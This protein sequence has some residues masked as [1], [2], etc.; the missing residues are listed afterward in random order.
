M[1]AATTRAVAAQLADARSCH[2]SAASSLASHSPVP[3]KRR[4]AGAERVC[5]RRRASRT[6]P[7]RRLCERDR[8][9]RRSSSPRG[10]PGAGPRHRLAIGQPAC[11]RIVEH[12]VEQVQALPQ[13]AGPLRDGLQPAVV[14][15]G[16][17]DVRAADVPADDVVLAVLM[18]ARS[19]PAL[20][21]R[22]AGA[23]LC[24]ASRA[25]AASA[26]SAAMLRSEHGGQ[27][28]VGAGHARVD[29]DDDRPRARMPDQVDADDAGEAGQGACASGLRARRAASRR[30]SRTG[31]MHTPSNRSH[32]CSSK[33]MHC[34][35]TAEHFGLI[36][37][38][39]SSAM[40]SGSPSTQGSSTIVAHACCRRSLRSARASRS[41]CA[42][43]RRRRRSHRPA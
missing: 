10:S 3:Q 30:S 7:S 35:L 12:R 28:F 25:H 43:A 2:R 37:G 29:L 4:S 6:T 26:R 1:R 27:P 41:R 34:R 19:A 39:H 23:G 21:V 22:V 42:C 8:P 32:P 5:R 31:P 13:G 38:P 24:G 9:S 20:A 15:Q 14:H 33:L 17:L 16:G 36:G 40:L 11:E 18:S